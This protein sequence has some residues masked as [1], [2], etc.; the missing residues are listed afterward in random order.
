MFTGIVEEKGK[1]KKIESIGGGVKLSIESPEIA[2]KLRVGDSISLNGVCQTVVQKTTSSFE[3]EAVEETVRKTTLG[4]LQHGDDVNLE[5]PLLM[6]DRLGGHLVLGHVDTVGEISHIEARTNSSVF[7]IKISPEYMKYV[8]PTGS[9]AI[10]GV[11]ITVAEFGDDYVRV[12]II[13]YTM[14]KTI[15]NSYHIGDHV[16]LEFDIIGKYVERLLGKEQIQT[17][18]TKFL[19]EKHLRELGF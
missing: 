18:E 16:N 11:S 4:L 2:K 12:S 7:T 10:D 13:P 14:E 3:V 19:T 9:I 15:F 1:V 5:L 17:E 8:A 6:N